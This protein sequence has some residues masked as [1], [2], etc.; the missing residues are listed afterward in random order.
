MAPTAGKEFLRPAQN[1]RRS[2][3]ALGDLEECGTPIAG[4]RRHALDQVIDFR[5]GAVELTNQQRSGIPRISAGLEVLGS[6]D[7]HAVHHLE[8]S[9]E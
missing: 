5:L 4:N 8:A 7:G 6:D 9:Q 1:R 3:L 2:V